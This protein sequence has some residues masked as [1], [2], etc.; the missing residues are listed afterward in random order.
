MEEKK[1]LKIFK[2]YFDVKK[3]FSINDQI[4]KSIEIDSLNR[5]KFI[6]FI[7]KYG[8]KKANNNLEKYKKFK[9]ILNILK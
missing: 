4:D 2:D 5:L 6:I 9:D 8:C 3:K 7:E 1:F